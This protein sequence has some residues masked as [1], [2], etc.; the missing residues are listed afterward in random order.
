M[1]ISTSS[2]EVIPVAL[3]EPSAQ[4]AARLDQREL[5]DRA[6]TALNLPIDEL[7][8]ERTSLFRSSLK[9]TVVKNT[10]FIEVNLAA[11]SAED[12]KKYLAA[13]T[14]TLIDIHNKRMEPVLQSIGARV[15]E[16]TVQMTEAQTQLTHLQEMLKNAGHP[17]SDGQFAPYIIAADLISK[18]NEKILHLTTEQMALAD[19]LFVVIA[20]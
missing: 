1:P 14:Q 3:I 4:A 20:T 10:N 19:S 11:Y 15:K 7:S 8:D 13:A 17:K 9:A 6:L 18:Q 16:N 2:K 5:E 12:A